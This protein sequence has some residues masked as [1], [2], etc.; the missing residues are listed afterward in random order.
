MWQMIKEEI[1]TGK[2]KWCGSYDSRKQG[3]AYA[4][5]VLDCQFDDM[6]KTDPDLK[7]E[8]IG[9]F[10]RCGGKMAVQVEGYQFYL[11]KRMFDV[12]GKRIADPHSTIRVNGKAKWKDPDGGRVILVVVDEIVSPELVKCHYFKGDGEVECPWGELTV[13]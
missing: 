1:S 2:C 9:D 10:M 6:G 4:P 7:D 13:A 11:S 5:E 12:Y 8:L 3:I